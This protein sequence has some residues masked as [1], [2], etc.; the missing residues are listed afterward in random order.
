MVPGEEPPIG[1]V[2]HLVAVLGLVHVVVE[3][4]TVD[5][6]RRQSWLS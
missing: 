1:D 4:S 3:T 2:G 6:V 5:A